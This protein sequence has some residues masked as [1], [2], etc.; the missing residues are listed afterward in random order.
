MVDL[1]KTLAEFTDALVAEDRKALQRMSLFGVDSYPG[2]RRFGATIAALRS[3]AIEPVG[4]FCPDC[5]SLQLTSDT[6][7]FILLFIATPGGWKYRG[8]GYR[9]LGDE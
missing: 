7:E 9:Y 4:A 5:Y 2:L 1:V 3:V 8:F 6:Q